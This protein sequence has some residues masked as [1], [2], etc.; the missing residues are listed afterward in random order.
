MARNFREIAVK[1]ILQRLSLNKMAAKDSFQYN[2][3]GIY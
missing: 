1:K 2:A 3:E